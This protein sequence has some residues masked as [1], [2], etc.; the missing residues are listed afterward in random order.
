MIFILIYVFSSQ[1]TSQAMYMDVCNYRLWHDLPHTDETPG[2]RGNVCSVTIY[3]AN[4][5]FVLMKIEKLGASIIINEDYMQNIVKKLLKDYLVRTSSVRIIDNIAV[6][7]C[8][9]V[10]GRGD[11]G[12]GHNY[13]ATNFWLDRDPFNQKGQVCITIISSYP[14]NITKNFLITMRLERLN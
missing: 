7:G 6:D 13:F 3:D 5:H 12:L 9:A 1:V 8:P 14:E 11:D 10:Y 2:E 4:N